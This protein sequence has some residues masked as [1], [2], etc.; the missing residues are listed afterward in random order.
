[1]IFRVW[2]LKMCNVTLTSFSSCKIG[3]VQ[4][5][6]VD[7]WAWDVEPTKILLFSY[8]RTKSS[9][10]RTFKQ[11]RMKPLP[12]MFTIHLCVNMV[13]VLSWRT[14][15]M[16]GLPLSVILHKRLYL[17]LW[18]KYCIYV[19]DTDIYCIL[20]GNKWGCDFNELVYG[21]RSHWP[22]DLEILLSLNLDDLQCHHV[23]HPLC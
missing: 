19:H 22:D 14:R 4:I 8:D 15:L 9:L 23:S 2:F 6:S 20:Q 16:V 3:Y 10:L 12:F 21:P 17:L 1:M 18:S 5:L 11:R 13:T 7:R